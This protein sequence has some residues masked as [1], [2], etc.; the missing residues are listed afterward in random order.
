M[1]SHEIL[2]SS[3]LDILFENRNKQYGAYAL[4]KF[5]ANRMGVALAISLSSVLLLL[6][7]FSLPSAP[8]SERS[9]LPDVGVV[10]LTNVEIPREELPPPA[11]V[12]PPK[13]QQVAQV[14]YNNI[15]IVPD[16]LAPE[17]LPTINDIENAVIGNQ[18]VDGVPEDGTRNTTVNTDSG[19][20]T[21]APTPEPEKTIFDPIEKQP[22]FPGGVE[23]WRSFLSRYLQAPDE[24]AAGERKTV[25]VRFMVSATGEVTGFEIVQSA[26]NSFDREVLRVMKKMPKWRPA[27]QNGHHIAVS[28]VQPVTFQGVEE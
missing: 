15:V 14:D 17:P 7:L 13:V 23:A 5:Y 19:D 27:I 8:S 6:F 24:L 2:Q 9:S 1:T 3:M 28:F 21:P 20:A 11:P 18:N 26:G 16:D 22:E 12:E 10:E 4:R 25:Q